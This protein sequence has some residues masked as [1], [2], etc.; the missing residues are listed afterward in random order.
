MRHAPAWALAIGSLAACDSSPDMS[1][2]DPA[3]DAAGHRAPTELTVARNRAVSDAMDFSDVL[4]FAN[5]D[6]GLIAGPENLK[7]EAGDGRSIWNQPAYEFLATPSPSINPSLQR[8]AQL[9]NRH[10]LYEVVPGIYQLRGFDLSNMTLIDGDTGWIIVDPLTAAETASAAMSFAMPVLGEKPVSAVIFT[11]SHVDHFGG[12]LG[13][14]GAAD[15]T[16]TGIE[17]V[18]PEGFIEEATSENIIAGSAMGR[19]A[20]YM[21]GSQLARSER[22][23]VDSGLGK[24]PALGTFGILE[25]TV[26]ISETGTERLIDGVRFIFQNASGTE[27]PAEFTFYLPDYKAYCGAEVVSRTMHNLYTL[28]GAKVRDALK[29]SSAIDEALSLFGE[30]DVYFGSHHWP[31]WGNVAV[32]SF[33]AGQRDLYKF[34]HDQTMRLA[35]SGMTPSEIAEEIAL[36]EALK[37]SFANNGYYGTL[38]HNA[39]AI[40]QAYLGWYDGHPSNLDPLPP[41]EA[42]VRYVQTMGGLKNVI[43][44]GRAAY[45][46]GDYRWVAE[47]MKHAVFAEPGNV[48]ARSLLA[49]TFD[50]LGYQGESGPWRDVYLSGAYELRHGA[51]DSGISLANALDLLRQMPVSNLFDA[52][53]VRLN[54]PDADG[55]SFTI[56]FVFSDIDESYVI[57]VENSV[58]RHY[59]RSPDPDADATLNVTHELYLRLMTNQTNMATALLT[60]EMSVDGSKVDLMGFFSLFDTPDGLFNIIEP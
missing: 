49:D 44:A 15:A 52:M 17:I 10:G 27:A 22:G 56:N 46:D 37:G 60:D 39:K 40:Y 21:Y 47:L 2:V 9:N 31:V 58:L 19:R 4:D 8:Q 33:L 24:N 48:E 45:D 26:T 13:I 5:A 28:R 18:A 3:A 55:K 34:I 30:A 7:I 20:M 38:K 6:R 12:I 41:T 11:H 50:Q 53:A 23:H 57:E 51:P 29:W 59:A 42:A 32:R 35:N 36:P 54:G 16:K 43:A 14:I 25:P 1:G